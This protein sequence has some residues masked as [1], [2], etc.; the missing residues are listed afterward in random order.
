MWTPK[1]EC[2]SVGL[3]ESGY[4]HQVVHADGRAITVTHHTHRNYDHIH[5]EALIGGRVRRTG[6]GPR[7][8]DLTPHPDAVKIANALNS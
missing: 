6:I 4:A 3:A 1:V 5:V 2:V 8:P 7:E